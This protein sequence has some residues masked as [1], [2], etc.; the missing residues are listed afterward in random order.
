MKYSIILPVRNGGEYVKECV[1]SILL[2]TL[3]DFSLEVLDNASTDGTAE[4][5]ASLADS[6]ITLHR[7]PQSLTIE[8]N[9]GR[10][11][12]VPKNEFMTMIGHDDVLEPFYLEEMD[13]LIRKHPMASLY[14]THYNYIDKDGQV[15]R[16]CLPMDEVQMSYE[17]LACQ[18]NNTIESTGTGYMLRASDYDKVGGIPIRYPN[19]IFADYELW[20]KVSSKTFKATSPKQAFRY[21]EHQSV[22]RITNGMLYLEAFETYIKFIAQL[23]G[24]EKF[25]RIINRYGRK[26]LLYFCES[27]SH[28][29]LKTSTKHRTIKVKQLIGRFEAMADLLIPGQ[30][31]DP[32]SVKRIKLADILDSNPAS[33]KLFNLYN[34]FILRGKFR[35]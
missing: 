35:Y 20:I 15:T 2:Q 19:L 34:N 25:S 24:D 33:R 5:I 29:L 16:P 14:Q 18:M 3:P 26:M 31:F 9:W 17:F 7:S 4:W 12:S 1:N 28:R 27:L 32:Q 13:D 10:I 22:S 8:Q 11:V 21:R 6:R 30:K 23:E